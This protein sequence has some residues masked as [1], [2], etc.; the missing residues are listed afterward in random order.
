M[1]AHAN[2]P[3]RIAGTVD[4]EFFTDRA[5]ELARIRGALTQPAAKLLVYGPRRMGKS[6]TVERAVRQ[7]VAKKGAAFVADL[8]T[9]STVADMAN[10][11]LEAAS[12]TLGRRWRDVAADFAK[13]V[14]GTLKISPD[15]ATGV[16][17]PSFEVG[18]RRADVEQQRES[19][20]RVLD[21]IDAMAAA[22]GVT[23]GVA[24]DEFQ[25]ITRFGGEDAEWHLRGVIQHH[26]HVSYVLAGSKPHLIRRMLEKGRAFYEL[27]EPLH[28][29]PM[30]P[31]HLARWIEQRMKAGGVG[32]TGA[33][34][35]IVTVAGPRTRD[36]VQLAMKC[37]D[38]G[39]AQGAV[40]PDDVAGAFAEL[41]ADR[42]DLARAFWN[43]CTA[44]QQ[45]VL[46]AVAVHATGLTTVEVLERFSLG[47]ASATSQALAAFVADGHLVREDPG[48]RYLYDSPYL[49][50]WVL[51]NAL[52]DL[53]ITL[54]VTHLASGSPGADDG[55]P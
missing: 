4:N 11:I 47:S 25:E 21:A 22:R 42:E 37:F 30:D 8:S 9:A 50:G 1:P 39:A 52:P 23:V 35:R 54:P 49:R 2:N 12:R 34:A 44:H 31:A 18:L 55:T 28:F 20:G 19:L 13:R 36:I 7:V 45:N 3:F 26:D 33:G 14:G 29:G 27:L 40:R 46:R 6:S 51:V 5:T 53:G 15:P 16:L 43:E 32:A 17:I 48:P 38:R 41:V 10:R 24:L